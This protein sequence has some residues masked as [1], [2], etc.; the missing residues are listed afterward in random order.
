MTV[1]K[2][3][4]ATPEKRPLKYFWALFGALFYYFLGKDRES[5]P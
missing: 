5:S 1:A 4:F 2:N 3:I